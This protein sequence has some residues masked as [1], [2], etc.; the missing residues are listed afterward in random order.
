[1]SL[2]PTTPLQIAD[3]CRV[4][5]TGV[6]LPAGSDL[7]PARLLWALS[8]NE[9]SFGANVTPHHESG[10]CPFTNGVYYKNN[11]DV[12]KQTA[13]I[14]CLAHMSYG[15]LQVMWYN[16][17]KFYYDA[18]AMGPQESLAIALLTDPNRGMNAAVAFLNKEIFGRQGCK[19]LDEIGDA[20]NSGNAKDKIIPVEYIAKLKTNYDVPLK[21][22]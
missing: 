11:P 15:P 2:M 22:K 21:E 3:I 8:G 4:Q 16:I 20:Y 12:R 18:G 17:V 10:Y 5:A 7:D 6:I 14:G 19:T 9:S 13:L 1:M